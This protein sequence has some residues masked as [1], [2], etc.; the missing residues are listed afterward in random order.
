VEVGAGG[1]PAPGFEQR[2]QDLTRRAR[3]RGRLEDDEVALA[4][5]RRDRA[6][7]GLDVAE[8]GLL[9]G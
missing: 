4:Q 2:L 8:I 1:Q 6:S 7:R 3:I 5:V 9:L